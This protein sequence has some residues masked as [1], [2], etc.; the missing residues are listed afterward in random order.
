MSITE[1]NHRLR[2]CDFIQQVEWPKGAIVKT[3][4]D[5]T[6]QFVALHERAFDALGTRYKISHGY[7]QVKE[8]TFQ[9]VDH[10][11]P[12]MPRV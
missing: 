12:F 1:Q 2:C 11:Y 7:F 6:E 8:T 9:V 4:D 10:I 3:E 5:V